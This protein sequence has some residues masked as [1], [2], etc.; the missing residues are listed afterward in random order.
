MAKL[1][2]AIPTHFAAVRFPYHEPMIQ[3]IKQF[4]GVQWDRTQKLWIVPSDC[5]QFVHQAAKAHGITCSALAANRCDNIPIRASSSLYDFQI[6]AAQRA[7]KEQSLLINF[8]TGLGKSAAALTATE[9]IN[10][11]QTLIVCPPGIV[12]TWIDE[13]ERW[14]PGGTVAV[15]ETTKDFAI[16]R[17]SGARY[18]IAPYTRLPTDPDE[19]FDVGAIIF[20]E[21]HNCKNPKS[22]RSK[23]CVALR[24]RNPRALCIETTATPI[25][26]TPKDLWQQL[27][28]LRPGVY[29]RY[30]NF[31]ARYCYTHHNGYGMSVE[32]LRED[33]AEEL[34]HRLAQCS[35]RVTKSE[36][37][38]LLPLFLVQAVRA[39]PNRDAQDE[40]RA[41][42]N[43][44][45]R[46]G[47]SQHEQLADAFFL[48]SRSDKIQMAVEQVQLAIDAGE[49]HIFALSYTRDTARALHKALG[50]SYYIDGSIAP[51][52]RDRILAHAKASRAAVTVATMKS[53]L[54]GKDL[55]WNST[56]VYAELYYSPLVMVQSLGR[57]NRLSGKAP[58]R[59][60]LCTLQGTLDELVSRSVLEKVRD[61][62][63]IFVAGDAESK[64]ESALGDAGSDEAYLDCLRSA[65]AS[66]DGSD[67]IGGY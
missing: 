20:D 12:S 34:Q 48:Q 47:P 6:S 29:G 65:A 61:C 43:A 38:H 49:T 10:G 28:L 26:N 39:R 33:T 7:L 66:F 8:E 4:P 54:E 55:T 52:E 42:T 25:A 35:V 50:A 53:L 63:A 11:V 18:L 19:F 3:S 27:D 60:I 57:F 62:N 15:A 40:L 17:E 31:C 56:A 1:G 9:S 2:P 32:G 30:W 45:V 59:A 16:L 23:A 36:V 41:L 46:G 51:D 67:S 58:T 44:F 24:A 14:A 22:K 5:V 21:S 64:L 37:Q 13:I